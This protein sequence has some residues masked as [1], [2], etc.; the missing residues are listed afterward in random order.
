[1]IKEG[2]IIHEQ[3]KKIIM[4]SFVV[5]NHRERNFSSAISFRVSRVLNQFSLRKTNLTETFKQV[6]EDKNLKTFIDAN[7]NFCVK[8][9]GKR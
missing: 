9:E 4:R 6:P 8:T 1:M 3:K 2:Q 7:A 5:L